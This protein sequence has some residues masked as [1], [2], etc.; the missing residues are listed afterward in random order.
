MPFLPPFN[1]TLI[2]IILAVEQERVVLG[3]VEAVHLVGCLV[4]EQFARKYFP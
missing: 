3:V 2:N 4:A 1:Y